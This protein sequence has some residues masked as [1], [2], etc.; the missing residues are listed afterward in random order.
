[1]TNYYIVVISLLLILFAVVLELNQ[2]SPPEVNLLDVFHAWET[3]YGKS[4]SNDELAIYRFKIFR[5]NYQLIQL[6]NER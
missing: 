2:S 4:Y 3:Q 5:D 1:M 6:H